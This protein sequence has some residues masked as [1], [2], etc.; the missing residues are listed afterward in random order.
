MKAITKS[1]QTTAAAVFATLQS[2]MLDTVKAPDG[3]LVP[4]LS[5][6]PDWATFTALLILAIGLFRARDHSVTSKE[7]GIE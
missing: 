3:S 7:A 1:W 4:D 5:T 6:S 2:L